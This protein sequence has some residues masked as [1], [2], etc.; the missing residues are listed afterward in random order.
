M[1]NN[2]SGGS[3]TPVVSPETEQIEQK[4]S[5]EVE[6][7][8]PLIQR[9]QLKFR[10]AVGR[11]MEEIPDEKIRT[12]IKKIQEEVL[13]LLKQLQEKSGLDDKSL[14]LFEDEI[15]KSK[16]DGFISKMALD[17]ERDLR[18]QLSAQNKV[19][20]E[21][22]SSTQ[23][24][25]KKEMYDEM[26]GLLQ[27][28]YLLSGL[29][30]ILAMLQREAYQD[31]VKVSLMFFDI[32][33]FKGVND[34][35]GHQAGDDAIT[36]VG[37]V[38][39]DKFQRGSDVAG[40]FGG[41]EFVVVMPKCDSHNAA[42]LAEDVRKKIEESRFTTFK[43]GQA[44]E[45]KVTVSIGVL[46]ANLHRFLNGNIDKAVDYLINQS[47][48]L[49]YESKQKGRNRVSPKQIELGEFTV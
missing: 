18:R 27:K 25:L 35:F 22:L 44:V 42:I 24:E 6:G 33:H 32:D 4:R 40:K 47:D 43:D 48:V 5:H 30:N 9:V 36:G 15:I 3:D 37:K 10:N 45:F 49:M 39:R 46:T 41:D 17:T 29:K 31:P 8:N 2:V 28:K 13:T 12:G 11:A 19:L 7:E 34:T 38:V 16:V 1:P 20:K 21:G 26:T 14:Q 23:A